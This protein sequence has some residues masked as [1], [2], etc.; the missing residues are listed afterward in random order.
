MSVIIGLIFPD[1]LIFF[2]HK[3]SKSDCYMDRRTLFWENWEKRVC[4]VKYSQDQPSASSSAPKLDCPGETS[5][6]SGHCC[7]GEKSSGQPMQ[8]P[9]SF[10]LRTEWTPAVEFTAR[11]GKITVLPNTRAVP[12]PVSEPGPGSVRR[13]W[14]QRS[15]LLIL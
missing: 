7:S 11:E 12:I 4:S 8:A 15:V 5:T 13:R 1:M 10:V 14:K 6:W 2:W 9:S 3:L